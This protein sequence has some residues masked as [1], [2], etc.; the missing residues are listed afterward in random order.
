MK[1][2]SEQTQ[3]HPELTVWKKQGS[4]PAQK[5]NDTMTQVLTEPDV[6]DRAIAILRALLD[7]I[8]DDPEQVRLEKEVLGFDAAQLVIYAN[9]TDYGN[10]LGGGQKH[11]LAFKCILRVLSGDGNTL[12]IR[13][14][15]KLPGGKRRQKRYLPPDL[16]W[17]KSRLER[18]FQFVFEEIFEH[19][20]KVAIVCQKGSG[21]TAVEVVVGPTVKDVTAE[22]VQR[23]VAPVIITILSRNRRFPAT[24]RIIRDQALYEQLG[25]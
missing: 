15:D 4:I 9:D 12:Q 19:E 10:V 5:R 11:L 25:N 8:T 20:A 24:L 17:D 14:A 6:A 7:E 3:G 18:V 13:L 2:H 21:A 1:T 22:W 16:E 23:L